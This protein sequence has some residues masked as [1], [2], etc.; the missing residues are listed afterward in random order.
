ME[1]DLRISD[2]LKAYGGLLTP[3][4]REVTESYYDYDLSLKE[5]SENTGISRQAVLDAVHTS[6]RELQRLEDNIG[7]CSILSELKRI[8]G[9]ME[10]EA[11]IA[12]VDSVLS[13]Y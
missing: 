10:K 11:I 7:L 3:R 5:I 6:A 4:Q 2:F 12:V 8:D 1:K 9:S 13:K